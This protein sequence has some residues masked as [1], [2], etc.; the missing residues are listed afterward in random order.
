[1]P[2]FKKDTF[3]AEPVEIKLSRAQIQQ[4]NEMIDHFK[5]QENFVLKY[6][7]GKLSFNFTLELDK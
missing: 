6:F 7:D 5:E 3:G 2:E 4:M 1:M